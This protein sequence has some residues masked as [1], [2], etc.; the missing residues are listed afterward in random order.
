MEEYVCDKCNGTGGEDNPMDDGYYDLSCPKCHGSGKLNWIENLFGKA[1][2][3]I[4]PWNPPEG[5]SREIEKLKQELEKVIGL[6]RR[7]LCGDFGIPIHRYLFP[8]NEQNNKK[9]GE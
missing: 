7:Y 5:Y 9:E 3:W 4:T 6:P 8:E 1:D 2:P